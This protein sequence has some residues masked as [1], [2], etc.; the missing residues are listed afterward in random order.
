VNRTAC[1]A[2]EVAEPSLD[3]E[4][5]WVNKEFVESGDDIVNR[6]EGLDGLNVYNVNSSDGY[7]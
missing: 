2:A 4:K 1:F 7:W 6:L 5:T 3:F